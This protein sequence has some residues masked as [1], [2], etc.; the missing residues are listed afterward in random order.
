M[1]GDDYIDSWYGRVRFAVTDALAYLVSCETNP[2]TD[3]MLCEWIDTLR[4]L[5]FGDDDIPLIAQLVDKHDPHLQEAGVRL[6]RSALRF[7]DAHAVLE[8]SLARLA[9]R[10]IDPWVL[11]AL[12]EVLASTRHPFTP[13]YEGLAQMH[14]KAPRGVGIMRNRHIEPWRRLVAIYEQNA[15]QTL[16]PAPRDIAYLPILEREHGTRGWEPTVRSI[17]TRLGYD[18]DLHFQRLRSL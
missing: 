4:A 9:S 7:S 12:V 5:R 2:T 16:R 8:P 14:G 3:G 1:I 17:L 15:I 6:A 18:P 11:E 10:E 13:V